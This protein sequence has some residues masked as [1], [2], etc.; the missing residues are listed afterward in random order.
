MLEAINITVCVG[1]K[2]LLRDVY[3]RSCPGELTV[4]IGPNGAGKSTLLK[5]LTG[6]L[7]PS[8]GD[9]M[10]DGTSIWSVPAIELAGRRAVLPQ[11]SQLSFPFSVEEVVMLG[12]VSGRHGLSAKQLRPRV[13]EALDRVGLM[14][15]L[16]RYYQELSGGE[17]QR[18]HLA[19]VLCQVWEPRQN[20]RANYLFLDEPTASLDLK[21]QIDVLETG[22]KYANEGGG[23]IAVLH[24]ID[25]ACVY[26]DKIFVLNHGNLVAHGTPQDVVTTDLLRSVYHLDDRMLETKWGH[27]AKGQNLGKSWSELRPS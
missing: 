7:S 19:R 27:L 25:L 2:K 22:R 5:C 6:D 15:Y 1:T 24:D 18:V 26:A 8:E 3:F 13:L 16:N 21:H 9:V 23:V 14:S 10:L 12:L 11:S 4:I 20:G 17:K